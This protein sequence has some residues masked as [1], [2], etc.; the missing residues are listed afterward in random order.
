MYC[1]H[2]SDPTAPR[3]H[4][5]AGALSAMLEK[6]ETEL[7]SGE[8]GDTLRDP[9]YKF[10]LAGACAMTL[11]C[12]I[13]ARSKE[14]MKQ[15]YMC[16]SLPHDGVLQMKKAL[17]GPGEYQDGVPY[18]FSSL[19]LIGTMEEAHSA[20]P[21]RGGLINVP[22]PGGLFYNPP[23]GDKSGLQ[24]LRARYNDER[25]GANVCG[26]CGAEDGKEGI[27]LR[28][29]AR[30]KGRKYCSKACQKKQWPTHKEVCVEA[31]NEETV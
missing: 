10:M 20:L 6:Y 13:P 7:L 28:S 4:H 17:H 19:G 26:G 21:S 23:K 18:D 3:D 1:S 22:G 29:C 30:C 2:C 9:G 12:H 5:D 24:K 27:H 25:Y 31:T 16:V 14:T 8:C 11:G 15:V